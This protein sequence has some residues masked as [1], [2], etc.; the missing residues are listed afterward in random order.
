[1]NPSKLSKTDTK[2]LNDARDALTDA[3]D[4]YVSA[5]Q[6]LDSQ[7]SAILAALPSGDVEAPTM[8]TALPPAKQLVAFVAD[9]VSPAWE[10]YSVACEAFRSLLDE[11][12][13]ELRDAW[14]SR[15]ERWQESEAGSNASEWIDSLSDWEEPEAFPPPSAEEVARVAVECGWHEVEDL[16]DHD[17]ESARDAAE[18]I[19]TAA[20]E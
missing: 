10:D 12:S 18:A 4:A 1:M 2:R 19:E 15:S 8:A 16:Y 5:R 7:L 6:D 20:Q 17:H 3:H 9:A 13:T 11:L 14:E